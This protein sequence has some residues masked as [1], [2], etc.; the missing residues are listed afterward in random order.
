MFGP[1]NRPPRIQLHSR[2]QFL[3]GMW[4]TPRPRI[5]KNSLRDNVQGRRVG[6]TIRSPDANADFR[7]VL[8]VFGVFDEDVPVA[9][10][11]EAIGVEEF[12]FADV[13]V[14]IDGFF[15]QTF[16]GVLALRVFVQVF[17]V[18]MG[19]SGILRHSC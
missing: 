2:P 7:I 6:P 15:N 14:T 4:A 9:V 11:V 1:N 10:V 12:K 19:G 5:T 17:H 3:R 13:T 8:V 16:V 18:G